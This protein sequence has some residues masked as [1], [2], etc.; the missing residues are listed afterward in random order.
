ME[1]M[2]PD[3]SFSVRFWRL[4]SLAC[5]S[6]RWNLRHGIAADCARPIWA[7]GLIQPARSAAQ[8][9]PRPRALLNS[10][11]V[12]PVDHELTDAEPPQSNQQGGSEEHSTSVSKGQSTS[13]SEGLQKLLLPWRWNVAA[14]CCLPEIC[15]YRT[16]IS[17]RLY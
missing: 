13:V 12:A 4:E 7:A 5:F 15:L 6:R 1:C 2:E 16:T 8:P 17:T 9:L 14:A 11:Q 10:R 3:R